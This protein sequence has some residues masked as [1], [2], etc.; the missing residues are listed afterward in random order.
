M[1]KKKDLS[2]L[3]PMKL[4]NKNGNVVHSR[5]NMWGRIIK[6]GDAYGMYKENRTSGF[7]HPDYKWKHVCKAYR[8]KVRKMK[9]AKLSRKGSN[10]RVKRVR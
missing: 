2:R 8:K 3:T 1:S 4:F 10:K 5:R 6:P 7:Y 9:I